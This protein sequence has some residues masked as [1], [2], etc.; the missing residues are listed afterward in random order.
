MPNSYNIIIIRYLFR[1]I[2]HEKPTVGNGFLFRSVDVLLINL[3]IRMYKYSCE[4][5]HLIPVINA[6]TRRCFVQK[7]F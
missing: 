6:S 7:H 4:R 1:K 3:Y 2:C 5:I